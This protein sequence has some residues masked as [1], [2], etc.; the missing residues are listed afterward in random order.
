MGLGAG[1]PRAIATR[2]DGF[3]Y[4][5]VE[6]ITKL[7]GL[8]YERDA[9]MIV[10]EQQAVESPVGSIVIVTAGTFYINISIAFSGIIYSIKSHGIQYKFYS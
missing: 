8:R 3:L 6:R 2:A 9:R 4:E 10:L 7:D 1:I 5:D